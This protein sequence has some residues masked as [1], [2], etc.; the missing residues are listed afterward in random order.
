MSAL[1]AMTVC[2][3]LLTPL[4]VHAAL[5]DADRDAIAAELDG[6]IADVV[7]SYQMYDA[8]HRDGIGSSDAD[9]SGGLGWRES[10][11]LRNY[12]MCWYA[13]RDTYWLDK[14]IDHTDRMIDSLSDHDGDGL[15]SWQDV[16]YSVG[17][18]DVTRLEPIGEDITVATPRGDRRVYYRS[19]GD[20]ITGHDYLLEFIAAD[21]FRFTDQTAGEVLGEAEYADPTSSELMPGTPLK[22]T[23]AGVAGAKFLVRTQAPEPCEYQVH[24]GMVTYPIAQFIEEVYA[25][26]GLDPKY[27]A[28]ADE[29]LKLL[30]EH[31]VPRWEKWWRPVSE[32]AGVY[33]FTDNPTQRFPLY[34]LPHNQYLAPART[35]LVLADLP[36]YPGAELC[37]ERARMMAGY[38]HQNLR[39]VDGDAYEW[40]YWDPLPDEEGVRSYPED[41]SH[42]TIDIGFAVEAAHRGVVFTSEDLERFA[43]TWVDVMW[44]GD[45]ENPRF[46]KRVN[47]NEGDHASQLEWLQLGE[48]D[49][50]VWD[51]AMAAF[52]RSDRPASMCPALAWLY[53]RVAGV[54]EAERALAPANTARVLA[55][56]Q[57]E[58]LMNAGFEVPGLGV[59]APAAWSFFRW[60]NTPADNVVEWTA[61]AHGGERAVALVGVGEAVNIGV[62]AQRTIGVQPPAS[63]TLSA[64]YKAEEGARPYLSIIAEDADGA[65]VQYDSSPSFPATDEWA[66][67]TWTLEMHEQARTVSVL[68]RNGAAGRIIYDDVEMHI[69]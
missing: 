30:D 27:R 67:A 64:W 7:A 45:E 56:A 46:G 13:I 51:L 48:V 8:L 68:L 44:S 43:R 19:G 47:T 36:G 58:G 34:S 38:F 26:E 11:Y 22:V 41:A 42:G 49:I 2:L 69:E 23:G 20:K 61:D 62:Q 21:R 63:V 17:L 59:G 24:D 29:Y 14:M 33:L 40:N 1:A 50:R 53:W 6:Q 35:L 37:A 5:T 54:S 55:M 66:Q 4:C 28:K 9:T 60:S 12:M 39:L 57:E 25:A 16:D 32:D 52:D 15:L 18:V 3:A 31:F 65:R 10:S